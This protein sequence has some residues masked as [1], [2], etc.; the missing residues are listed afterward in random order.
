MIEIYDRG[1]NIGKSR[2]PHD[3]PTTFTGESFIGRVVSIRIVFHPYGRTPLRKAKG[4]K[5]MRCLVGHSHGAA[6]ASSEVSTR[7]AVN[8]ENVNRVALEFP[9]RMPWTDDFGGGYLIAKNQVGSLVDV[10]PV[11]LR[12]FVS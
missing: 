9:F 10:N 12:G 8:F 11:D 5:F 3:A 7:G 6:T 4:R 1:R 2:P